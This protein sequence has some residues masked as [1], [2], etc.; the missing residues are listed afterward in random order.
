MSIYYN[1]FFEN[2]PY[3][4]FSHISGINKIVEYPYQQQI[5]IEVGSYFTSFDNFNANANFFITDGLSS[6][7]LLGIPVVGIICTIVFYIFDA[8]SSTK[9]KLLPI[10]L[11]ANSTIVLMNVS[12][13][14][15]L[16]SGGLFFFIVL[17]K[18]GA[19]TINLKN[20]Y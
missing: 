16:I 10:L 5:G 19:K 9:Y 1:L 15:A 3:L 6:I 13:F 11:I 18:F 14:T 2:H 20:N 17:M 8:T 4:Y 7:G 12:L